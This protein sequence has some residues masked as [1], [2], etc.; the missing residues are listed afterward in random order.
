MSPPGGEKRRKDRL[1]QVELLRVGEKRGEEKGWRHAKED[2]MKRS[3]IGSKELPE[4]G[5]RNRQSRGPTEGGK[6]KARKKEKPCKKSEEKGLPLPGRAQ[7]VI[8]KKWKKQKRLKGRWTSSTERTERE[9][10]DQ[11]PG[12]VAVE[13]EPAAA[14][15]GRVLTDPLTLSTPNLFCDEAVLNGTM[16]EASDCLGL[17]QAFGREK[18]LSVGMQNF[19]YGDLS[20]WLVT[21]VDEL[22]GSCGK[23]LSTGRLFPLPSSPLVLAT[24]FPHAPSCVRNILRCLVCALNSLNGEGLEGPVMASE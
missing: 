8:K 23:T 21:S 11:L 4:E 20:S 1:S 17:G 18:E 24:L 3:D 7:W 15:E 10:E 22:F 16:P 14:G 5:H 12:D 19:R 9:G 13:P 2:K 6:K